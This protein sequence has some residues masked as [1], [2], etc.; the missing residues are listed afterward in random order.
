MM[1]FDIGSRID[2]VVGYF[3][4]ILLV[5]DFKALWTGLYLFFSPCTFITLVIFCYKTIFGMDLCFSVVT[6]RL[7]YECILTIG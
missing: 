4:V 5:S 1:C 7:L 6:F 2:R 3:D